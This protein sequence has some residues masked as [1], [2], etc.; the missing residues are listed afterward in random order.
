[1]MGNKRKIIFLLVLLIRVVC[2]RKSILKLGFTLAYNNLWAL[3]LTKYTK[4]KLLKGR[5]K[6][7]DD[8]KV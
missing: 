2:D 5:H 8:E 7:D 6:L 3:S 4:I 1:M